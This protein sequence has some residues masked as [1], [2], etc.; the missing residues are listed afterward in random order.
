MRKV[1]IVDDDPH[2][3]K[4]VDRLLPKELY[5]LRSVSCAEDAKAL[6]KGF[7]PELILLDVMMPGQSG[8]D[9]CRYL[10]SHDKFSRI[11]VIMLTAKDSQ[12]DRIQAFDYGAD[13]YVTKPFHIASLARKINFLF[14]KKN[15][16]MPLENSLVSP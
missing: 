3:F 7:A 10:R 11:S 8:I 2:V 12:D 13:D 5:D 4:I 15:Q 9:F 16:V 14:Q 1:L 6:L